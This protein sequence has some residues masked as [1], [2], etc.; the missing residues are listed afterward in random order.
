MSKPETTIKLGQAQAS[1]FVNQGDKGPFRTV[2]VQR[3]YND[4]KTGEW[5]SSNS[6]TAMQLTNA[7][8]VMQRALDYILERE[9]S[10]TS[11]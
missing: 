4:E 2:T 7:I 10:S 8:A 1:I 5:Q 11:A 9:G 3:R 6:Y